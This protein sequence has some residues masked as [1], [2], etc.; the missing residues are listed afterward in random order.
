MPFLDIVL[1]E[2]N[3]EPIVDK[4]IEDLTIAEGLKILGEI[5]K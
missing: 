5:K 1:R 3:G 2:D 4:Q